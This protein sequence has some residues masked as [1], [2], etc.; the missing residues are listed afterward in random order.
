MC[1]PLVRPGL[2]KVRVRFGFIR[3]IGL[4]VQVVRVSLVYMYWYWVRHG[5]CVV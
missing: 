2:G 5:V 3:A 4:K 1:V